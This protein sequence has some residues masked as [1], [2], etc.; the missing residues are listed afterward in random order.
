MT[1]TAGGN[2]TPP[3]LVT[4]IERRA[5]RPRPRQC[6]ARADLTIDG[7]PQARLDTLD[8]PD[9]ETLLHLCRDGLADSPG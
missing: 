5:I 2:S 8:V 4:Q 6:P 7:V 3:T 9:L 1:G